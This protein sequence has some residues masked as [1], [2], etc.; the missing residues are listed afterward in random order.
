MRSKG[1][2]ARHPLPWNTR[3]R[4]NDILGSMSYIASTSGNCRQ[5]VSSAVLL[6]TPFGSC[7]CPAAESDRNGNAA[8]EFD[9]PDI[10]QKNKK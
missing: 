5:Q 6:L 2:N 10:Q 1:H 7:V 3:K 9:R 8:R 4:V